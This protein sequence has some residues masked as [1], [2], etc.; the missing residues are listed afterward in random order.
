MCEMSITKVRYPK[1]ETNIYEYSSLENLLNELKRFIKEKK[2]SKNDIIRIEV[3]EN[4]RNE[5]S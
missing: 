5:I 1:N 4:G 3:L 2:I